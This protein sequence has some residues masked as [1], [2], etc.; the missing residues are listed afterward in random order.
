[1]VN[2]FRHCNCGT[3]IASAYLFILMIA[4]TA[5]VS[6]AMVP[7]AIRAV[8]P[9]TEVKAIFFLTSQNLVADTEGR[10]PNSLLFGRTTSILSKLV[11][12]LAKH[13]RALPVT[14]ELLTPGTS[15]SSHWD[16]QM[17]AQTSKGTTTN[18]L[19]PR[20]TS[21]WHSAMTACST[22]GIAYLIG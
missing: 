4:I 3:T 21:L 13:F 22:V 12:T 10:P 15:Y 19:F 9:K 7:I 5:K 6:R 20:H 11:R 17:D 16:C 1:M 14:Q 8:T 18:H 2:L